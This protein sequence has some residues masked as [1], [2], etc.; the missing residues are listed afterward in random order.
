MGEVSRTT[1]LLKER[2]KTNNQLNDSNLNPFSE[3]LKKQ[4]NILEFFFGEITEI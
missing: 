3:N 4:L 1:V 2:Q